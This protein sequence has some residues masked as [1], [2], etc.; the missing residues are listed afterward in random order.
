M[1]R[2][3]HVVSFVVEGIHAHDIASLLG[4]K[5]ISVRAGHHCAQPLMS[6]LGI[7]SAIRASF[8][9][10]NEEGEVTRFLNELSEIVKFLRGF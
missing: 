1:Q 7:E 3:G 9:C 6:E 2:S 10:Y 5:E 4:K 8:S